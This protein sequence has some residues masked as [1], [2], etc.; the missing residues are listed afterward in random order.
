VE[1]LLAGGMPEE[2]E[3]V[4]RGAK[5]AQ[6][7]LGQVGLDFAEGRIL[8]AAGRAAEARPFLERALASFDG[9]GL[10]L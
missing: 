9:S 6:V 3:A 4:V 7:D 2:A 5:G 10:R 8:L 1:G